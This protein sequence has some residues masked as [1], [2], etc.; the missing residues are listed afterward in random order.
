MS[1][2]AF[3]IGTT[4]VAVN[5][6]G[7]A[8]SINKSDSRFEKV[9]GIL[10]SKK[11]DELENVLN[12]PKAVA[13]FS[14]GNIKVFNG[15][16]FYK[17][18]EI[19]N[20][21]TKRILEYIEQDYPY[22]PLIRFMDKLMQNPS[23]NS[24]NQLYSFLEK[25]NL[26][27]TDEGDFIAQKA[28]D[29]NFKDYKTGTKD[30]SVGKVVKEDRALI[31]DNPSQGCGRGLHVGAEDYVND[32]VRN[33]GHVILVK[34]N[35][36]NVCSV[37]T[38]NTYQ[39]I[40]VCEYKVISVVGNKAKNFESSYAPANENHVKNI[41]AKKEVSDKT[42]IGADKAY[43]I[44]KAGGEVYYFNASR[45]KRVLNSKNEFSINGVASTSRKYFRNLK[46]KFYTT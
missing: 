32:F 11:Y 37:P 7:T 6:N 27:I 19:N 33:D 15:A 17:D 23:Q 9:L 46:V 1:K 21:L 30:N 24:I 29:K 43:E 18:K 2:V 36:K 45:K 4:F 31:S 13:L 40:R 16:V 35:P 5:Y 25:Y 3:I 14:S 12:I 10:K 39:K 41:S 20:T 8:Y 44:V 34:I 38:E 42:P 22:Q 26:P 28:V